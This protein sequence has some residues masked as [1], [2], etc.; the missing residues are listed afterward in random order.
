V[1]RIAGVQFSVE[2]ETVL[3]PMSESSVHGYCML[4]PSGKGADHSPPS[5]A[6]FKNVWNIISMV[7][8]CLQCLVH[9]YGG[10][11]YFILTLRGACLNVLLLRSNLLH[12]P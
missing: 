7:P 11:F 3:L 12:P 9:R 5:N 2:A 4:F 6:K 1:G 8:I 10:D